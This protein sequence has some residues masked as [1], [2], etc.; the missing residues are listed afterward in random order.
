MDSYRRRNAV[1]LD[2]HRGDLHG[3]SC[4]KFGTDG[5][6]YSYLRGRHN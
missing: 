6:G 4:V 3:A 2:D 5:N 1:E